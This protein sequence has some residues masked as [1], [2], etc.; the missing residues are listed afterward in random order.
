MSYLNQVKPLNFELLFQQL[1]DETEIDKMNEA[2][3]LRGYHPTSLI[4][5]II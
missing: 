1:L 4:L 3:G 2:K 5:H